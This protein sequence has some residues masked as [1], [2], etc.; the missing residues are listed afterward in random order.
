MSLLDDLKAAKAL[1]ADPAKWAKEPDLSAESHC[2][3]TATQCHAGVVNIPGAI[4][5]QRMLAPFL[6][7]P[8]VNDI[9]SEGKAW[10]LVCFNDHPDTTHA[11]VLALFDRAID[12]ALS[13]AE[14]KK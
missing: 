2:I 11:D 4:R 14:S 9:A 5:L 7:P 3:L 6:P 12:A 10:P 1:I 8:F 13:T